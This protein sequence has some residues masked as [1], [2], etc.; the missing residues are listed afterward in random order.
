[1][2]TLK[3]KIDKHIYP[4]LTSDSPNFPDDDSDPKKRENNLKKNCNISPTLK[5]NKNLNFLKKKIFFILLEFFD[6]NIYQNSVLFNSNPCWA[7]PSRIIQYFE[8]PMA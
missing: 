7:K 1:M 6:H 2:E 5:K 3:K 4:R 8:D